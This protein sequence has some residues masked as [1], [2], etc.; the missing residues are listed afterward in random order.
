MKHPQT[1]L[2]TA[3]LVV[4]LL[5]RLPADPSPSAVDE[6]LTVLANR[7]RRLTLSVVREHDEPIALPDVADE[8]A[9]REH[10]QPVTELSP[11]T[12]AQTYISIYHDHLPRLV[13]LGILAYDQERDLVIPTY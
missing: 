4:S 1:D 11:E 6:A 2:D 7:R 8:V 3:T 13:D 12:V 5:D 9:V 10:G